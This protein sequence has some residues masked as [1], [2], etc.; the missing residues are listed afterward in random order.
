MPIILAGGFLIGLGIGIFYSANW[1]LGTSLVPQNEAGRFLGL[2]NLAG[3]GAGAIG[4]YI[5]GVI[6][7]SASYSLLMVVYAL[8]F[9]FSILALSQIKA[10]LAEN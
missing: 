5:G 2:S 9:T 1:A 7:D 6:G 3:A 4:A 8:M 10:P